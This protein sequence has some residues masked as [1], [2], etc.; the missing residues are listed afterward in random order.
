MGRRR[1]VVDRPTVPA[2]MTSD[3]PR[4][5]LTEDQFIALA[6]AHPVVPVAVEVL[7]DRETAV[8]LFEKLAGDGD[9]FLLE[10][11]EGGE[12]WGRWSFVGWDPAF[13][14]TARDGV[15]AID[16]DVAM[17]AGDPLSVL[18]TLIAAHHTPEP[19][20]LG[21]GD[22]PPL[23]SGAVG[24]L[25]YDVV[26]YVEHLPARPEDDRG[27]PEMV[28]QFV[29]ATAARY[30]SAGSSPTNTLRMTTTRSRKRSTAA[31]APTN[32]HTISGSP[33]SSSGLAGRCS[34]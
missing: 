29:G 3:P 18:E 30:C 34:T 32:C 10:S 27:L 5:S 33:R 9:G 21:L 19:R 17:P 26:R 24:Y 7:G 31:I 12:R 20:A 2:R 6:A 4:P 28:W 11:V 13:T 8:G 15:C 23:H 14:L 22:I 25:A 1:G 16:A